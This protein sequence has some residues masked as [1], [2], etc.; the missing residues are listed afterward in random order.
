M[1]HM[2][3]LTSVLFMGFCMH[4][5]V[6]QP[7]LDINTL[8][9]NN[10]PAGYFA[11]GCINL[12]PSGGPVAIT[13]GAINNNVSFTSSTCV[14]MFPGFNAVAPPGSAAVY[15]A[16]V[17]NQQLTATILE[18]ANTTAVGKFQKVEFG[19][20]LPAALKQ[21]ITTFLNAPEKA[22]TTA[23]DNAF[24]HGDG[25]KINPYDPDQISIDALFYAPN[26]NSNA[27]V[28]NGF[29]YKKYSRVSNLINWQN[30]ATDYEWR[31]RFAPDQLGTWY[32]VIFVY[33]DKNR[34]QTQSYSFSFTVDHV[35]NPGYV[36]VNPV[37]KRYL[38]LGDGTPF[39]PIGDNYAWD[40]GNAKCN[41]LIQCSIPDEGRIPPDISTK[42]M[43]YRQ[44]LVQKGGNFTRMIMAPWSFDIE[45]EYLCNYER[46]Q[47]EMWEMDDWVTANEQANIYS[48]LGLELHD[49]FLDSDSA[50]YSY[51]FW[52][53]NPYNANV[54]VSDPNKSLKG[55]D[56][57]LK[58]KDFFISPTAKAFYKKKLRYIYSR[59]GYS[60]RIAMFEMFT[61]LD[62]YQPNFWDAD[63]T[64]RSNIYNWIDEMSN[65]L[66]SLG[67]K[68]LMT[69][70]H[71]SLGGD[72]LTNELWSKSGIDVVGVHYYNP[73]ENSQR[74]RVDNRNLVW[75]HGVDKP[76]IEDEDDISTAMYEVDRC[77]NWPFHN[78][79]WAS[80]LTGS[81]SPGLSWDEH[82]YTENWDAGGIE[83]MEN[84][85]ALRNFV[86]QIDFN[87]KY[88]PYWTVKNADGSFSKFE[89]LY[90]VN[91]SAVKAYGWFHNRSYIY[92]NTNVNCFNTIYCAYKNSPST[93]HATM[94][95]YL[96]QCF[97][98]N[99]LWYKDLYT[100]FNDDNYQQVF[101]PQADYTLYP[102]TGGEMFIGGFP[103]NSCYQ[104]QWYS[105]WGKAAGGA[106]QPA[107]SSLAMTN[108]QGNLRVTIVPPTG[109]TYPG[110]WAFVAT[111][112][113]GSC[114][115][116]TSVDESTME[117][118]ISIYPN[119]NKG[120]F[121]LK[122][123][124]GYQSP[125]DVTI[126][127]MLGK[128]VYQSYKN[129]ASEI[130]VQLENPAA[131][132]YSV[133]VNC[134]GGTFVKKMVVENQ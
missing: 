57:V 16:L 83:Y 80:A 109:G 105:T 92:R 85:K 97:N 126:Y 6:A 58:S 77:T 119:S 33:L 25:T 122:V 114:F 134:E 32:G 5:A 72:V 53:T 123:N 75:A 64:I 82:K 10:T 86:N 98:D 99:A 106:L 81:L 1:E 100:K 111:K 133:K 44:K 51:D 71:T 59:W 70:S 125:Y 36:K 66:K 87:Q 23:Y 38:Q 65:Y 37:N 88:T 20:S 17:A 21:K 46:R 31:V 22:G 127:D 63:P 118:I 130:S 108:P 2:K 18:P 102:A 49:V 124:V 84:Y 129:T 54:D 27:V 40:P 28:K 55:V 19:I 35:D 90:M 67:D 74:Y 26:T 56:G 61:E 15:T 30:E 9:L 110:D 120:A 113:G 50:H 24:N 96:T 41:T 3:K 131:G 78:N 103:P 34:L 115:K 112:L 12:A 73:R 45:R 47:I 95:S 11:P 104:V 43:D 13:M 76:L 128:L 68:H 62:Q 89:T 42:Y 116:P 117:G 52:N 94:Q 91:G 121:Q 4:Q 132:L 79:L 107:W 8:A 48:I 60:T 39:F 93:P 29:Y 69:A 7:T 101:T 14:T